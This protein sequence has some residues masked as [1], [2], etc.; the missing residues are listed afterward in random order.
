VGSRANRTM[1]RINAE[2]V[3]MQFRHMIRFGRHESDQ[4]DR[5]AAKPARQDRVPGCKTCGDVGERV[6]GVLIRVAA[7]VQ[8]AEC[9]DG[10][11]LSVGLLPMRV[12]EARADFR[13][14]GVEARLQQVRDGVSRW[15]GRRI[16]RWK[17]A[18]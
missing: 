18:T 15:I 7:G 9:V 10:H 6:F 2:I 17:K 4:L 3:A 14:V 8:G 13:F 11:D 5:G 1:S 16:I 12:E